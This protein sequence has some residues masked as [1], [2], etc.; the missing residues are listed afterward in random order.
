MCRSISGC[1]ECP[2]MQGLCSGSECVMCTK[3]EDGVYV[4]VYV[5]WQ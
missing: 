1:G 2:W 4:C 3:C 5:D